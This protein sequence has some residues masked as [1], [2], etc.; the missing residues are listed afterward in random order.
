MLR[1]GDAYPWIPRKAARN[2][3]RPP[4]GTMIDEAHAECPRC[5]GDFFAF[6]EVRQDRILELRVDSSRPGFKG[7]AN[8]GGVEFFEYGDFAPEAPPLDYS[9]RTWYS[10]HLSAMGEPSL[11]PGQMVIIEAYRF[12]WLRT[13]HHPIA[14]R[15]ALSADGGASLRAVELDGAGGYEPGNPCV[16]VDAPLSDAQWARLLEQVGR[17][18]PWT[19]RRDSSLTGCDGA[20]WL[21]EARRSSTRALL[22]DWSPK[23]AAL[24]DTGLLFLELAGLLPPHDQIY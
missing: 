18:N 24:R 12:L 19:G 13:F 4:D 17:L 21:L 1:I 7:P 11:L 23:D 9:M 16:V 14:V 10:K 22:N 20:Q 2:G 5:A 8:P 3:G 15:A 6:V